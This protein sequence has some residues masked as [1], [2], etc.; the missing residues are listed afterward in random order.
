MHINL[1]SSVSLEFNYFCNN[2]YIIFRQNQR[3]KMCYKVPEREELHLTNCGYSCNGESS[4]QFSS[5]AQLCLTICHPMDCSML[6]LPVHHQFL[7]F[8]QTH[9]HWVHD[10]IQSSHP[11]L[12]PPLNLNLSQHQGLFKWV[13][14]SHQVTKVLEYRLDD[15]F[16]LSRMKLFWYP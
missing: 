8:T 16:R 9:L 1:V 7:E 5:V 14:S 2:K 13:S 6:G 3:W 11:L 10:A 12:S 4:V 15:I